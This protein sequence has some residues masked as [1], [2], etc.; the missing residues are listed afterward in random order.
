MAPTSSKPPVVLIVENDILA[1]MDAADLLM[2]AGC[3]VVTQASADH[4]LA[5]LTVRSDVDVL[6]TDINMPGSLTSSALAR[7]VDRRWPAMAI[8][9]IS[10][11]GKP[12]PGELPATTWFLQKPY[13]PSVLVEAVKAALASIEI[14]RMNVTSFCSG[15]A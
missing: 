4:A 2:D 14:R 9:A 15:R 5:V 3:R 8:I 6:L 10:G 11:I 12:A 7:I 1:R 13:P